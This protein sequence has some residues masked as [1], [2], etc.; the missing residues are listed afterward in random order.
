MNRIYRLVWNR[1]L[2][3][4]QVASELADARGAGTPPGG[5]RRLPARRL[6][7]LCCLAA[8]A[9]LPLQSAMAACSPINPAN[10]ATVTCSGAANPL[11]PSYA[12]AANNLTVNVVASG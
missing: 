11:A 7:A 8:C 10:G 3:V 4:L 5:A 1:A 12:S 2:R 6:L 9:A